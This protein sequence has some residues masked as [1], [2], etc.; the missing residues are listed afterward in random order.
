MNELRYDSV[1]YPFFLGIIR[2][3]VAVLEG[4]EAPI[5][6][7]FVVSNHHNLYCIFLICRNWICDVRDD[8][9]NCDIARVDMSKLYP[10]TI[11]ALVNRFYPSLEL[12]EALVAGQCSSHETFCLLCTCLG[13]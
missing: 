1:K 7:Y 5:D 4:C 2:T 12:L 10:S 8:L 13:D 6:V 11:Y 3:S 9:R